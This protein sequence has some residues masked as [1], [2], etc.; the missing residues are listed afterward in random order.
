M[1]DYEI[2]G[3]GITGL[4]V[5]IPQFAEAMALLDSLT[6]KTLAAAMLAIDKETELLFERTQQLVPIGPTG[7]LSASGNTHKAA[8]EGGEMTAGI[9]Y[10]GP[11]GSGRSQTMIVR[12]AGTGS[13]GKGSHYQTLEKSQQIGDVDYAVIV[14]EDLEAHHPM[15]QAKFVEQPVRGAMET[16]ASLK[17]M[18]RTMEQALH[19]GRG[20][21]NA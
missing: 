16:G 19:L 10:G 7:Q 21:L 1:A 12:L 4:T 3:H 20:S 6:P 5:G 13:S 18:Q 2:K 11:A 15:G 9:S 8:I 17:R 14:H